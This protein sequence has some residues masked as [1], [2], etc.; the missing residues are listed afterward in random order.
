[1]NARLFRRLNPCSFADV[2]ELAFLVLRKKERKERRKRGKG[3]IP[4][5]FSAASNYPLAILRPLPKGEGGRRRGKGAS[6]TCS[7]S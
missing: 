2:L 1:M 6:T 3:R 7:P 4:S 5:P